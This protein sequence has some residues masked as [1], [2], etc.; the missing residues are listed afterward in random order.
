MVRMA[1][2][3]RVDKCP[4]K[5]P[6]T[7]VFIHCSGYMEGEQSGFDALDQTHIEYLS[8]APFSLI[9]KRNYFVPGY[10]ITNTKIS[11]VN[12][13]SRIPNQFREYLH[14]IPL[15]RYSGSATSCFGSPIFSISGENV[16]TTIVW[17]INVEAHP[18]LNRMANANN[19]N[20]TEVGYAHCHMTNKWN[21]NNVGLPR[22]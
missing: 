22:D 20:N 8:T 16:C 3:R 14:S 5:V 9:S 6:R 7:S 10:T 2:K 17:V 4:R 11:L 12:K 21:N 13:R 19:N 18:A 15:P 1:D